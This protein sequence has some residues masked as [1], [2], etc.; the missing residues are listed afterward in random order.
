MRFLADES[1]D[2]RVVQALRAAGHDVVTVAEFTQ[3]AEDAALI[4][5]ATRE[6]RIFV[7]ED[8]DFGQL[9]YAAGTPTSGVILLR[10][11]SRVRAS[12]P[13]AVVG[14]VSRHGAKLANRFAVLQP[15]RARL[16]EA[17]RD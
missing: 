5:M 2:F 11:P 9:V 4:D 12:L 13:A 8:R 6:Q 10:Y 1:C 3:G 15:G 14:F 17:P 16:G 7:T